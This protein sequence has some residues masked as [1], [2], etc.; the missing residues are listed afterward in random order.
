MVDADFMY[1]INCAKSTKKS[2]FIIDAYG[3]YGVSDGN[4]SL[5]VINIS[6]GLEPGTIYYLNTVIIKFIIDNN[7]QNL[8]NFMEKNCRIR[9]GRINILDMYGRVADRISRSKAIVVDN[10]KQNE[11]FMS[12]I[13]G[14]SSDGANKYIHL[15]SFIMYIYKGFFPINNKDK[16]S[17]TVYIDESDMSTVLAH[18]ATDK[19]KYIINDFVN[20]L[21]IPRIE[22]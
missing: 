21:Y 3:I 12:N 9:Y 2:S 22:Q 13:G 16:V 7:I 20:Y 10:M 4:T 1:L 5:S 8:E 15:N 6:T 14:K 17:M 11:D 18:V 19:G